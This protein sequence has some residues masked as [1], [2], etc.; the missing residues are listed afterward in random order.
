MI[1]LDKQAHFLSGGFL[2]AALSPITTYYEQPL[3]LC[4][5]PV[6]LAAVLKEVYD[7]SHPDK[8]TADKWDAFATTLG[9][10]AMYIW[11]SIFNT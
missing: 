1:S 11:L 3:Y 7:A 5:I 2:L 10:I 8:H 9:G 6:I 4:L